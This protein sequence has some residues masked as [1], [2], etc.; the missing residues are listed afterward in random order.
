[1]ELVS[2]QACSETWTCQIVTQNGRL[3]DLSAL[4]RC[5]HA[6][7]DPFVVRGVEATIDGELVQGNGRL[8][9]RV[10][11]GGE[12]LILAPLSRKVQLNVTEKVDL[13]P[14][15]KEKEAYE[16][17]ASLWSGEPRA[18]RVIGPLVNAK[19]QDLPVLEVREF[20]WRG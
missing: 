4:S 1:M 18:V 17:L 10:S 5:V 14:T 15:R 3:P 7:G 11:G 6:V 16:R 13:R 12:V 19:S 2:D 8:A 9:F 20:F